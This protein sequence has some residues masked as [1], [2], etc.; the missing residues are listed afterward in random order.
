[1]FV[2]I[3]RATRSVHI[4]IKTIKSPQVTRAFL[5]AVRAKHYTGS[6]NYSLTTTKG[7][8]I[9]MPSKQ[10]APVASM[11]LTSS[12]PRRVSSTGSRRFP[13]RRQTASWSVVKSQISEVLASHRF[14]DSREE[15]ETTHLQLFARQV[16]SHAG[17]EN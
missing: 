8:P 16:C 7:L 2:A 5:K 13:A 11:S 12:T 10:R 6:V 3:D 15:L 14:H 4:E 9:G 1:M 17:P